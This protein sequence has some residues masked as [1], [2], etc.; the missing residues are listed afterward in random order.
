MNLSILA[1]L[2]ASTAVFVAANAVLKTYA[3]QGGWAVLVGA[4]A[5]FC[6]GN[7]L[8]V[9]VM[10]GNGLGVAI[11]LSVVFQLVAITAMAVVV[12]GE[13]PSLLQLAGMALGI[14]A[15]LMI[16]WPEAKA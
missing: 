1:W 4:L 3:M 10:R 11:A 6:L 7:T 16:A 15:V 2:A 5:L 14:V 9:Q 12:F 13:R 8:M